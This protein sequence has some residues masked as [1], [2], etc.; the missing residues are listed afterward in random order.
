MTF[1]NGALSAALLPTPQGGCSA[2]ALT[3]GSS[4]ATAE[5]LA[6]AYNIE[7]GLLFTNVAVHQHFSML[8]RS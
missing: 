4:A 8:A 6:A 2:S 1:G 5:V 7:D 3:V